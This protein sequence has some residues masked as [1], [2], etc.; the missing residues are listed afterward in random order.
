MTNAKKAAIIAFVNAALAV[1]VTFGLPLS[2][3]Q[4]GA[5][6]VLVNA[7]LGLYVALSYK[8]SPMRVPEV[9]TSAPED[10]L[11]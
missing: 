11:A 10:P 2:E 7:G 1:A 4:I 5:L 3:V 6:G 8:N 9:N